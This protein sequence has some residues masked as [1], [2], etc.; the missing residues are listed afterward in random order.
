MSVRILH[1]VEKYY[2][3]QSHPY[4]EHSHAI[5][6]PRLVVQV[7]LLIHLAR[8]SGPWTLQGKD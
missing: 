7:C 1:Q 2:L 3:Y 6:R 5:Y 8:L 4:L